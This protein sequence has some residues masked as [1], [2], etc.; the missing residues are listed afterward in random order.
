M[1]NYETAFR[2]AYIKQ[3][4]LPYSEENWELYGT[5]GEITLLHE[6]ES[7]WVL[8]NTVDQPMFQME[9]VNVVNKETLEM[10]SIEL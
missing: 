9:F 6:N 8:L 4:N 10:E 5:D 2:E 7:V 1:K 3:Q